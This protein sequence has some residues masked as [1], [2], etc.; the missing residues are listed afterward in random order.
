MNRTLDQH[1][2]RRPSANR[3]PEICSATDAYIARVKCVRIVLAVFN[4]ALGKFPLSTF[5]A[6]PIAPLSVPLHQLGDCFACL[7]LYGAGNA[8]ES[9]F[10]HD[11]SQAGRIVFPNPTEQPRSQEA[12][13]GSTNILEPHKHV[14]E[15]RFP[16]QQCQWCFVRIVANQ[17]TKLF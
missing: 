16:L 13:R 15:R 7:S 3:Q 2:L 4:F 10:L 1:L 5:V 6:F 8:T 17:R 11:L 14:A 12:W 9:T